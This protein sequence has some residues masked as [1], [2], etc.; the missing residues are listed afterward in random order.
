[1]ARRESKARPE[2][3][4]QQVRRESPARLGLRELLVR[5]VHRVPL[6]RLGQPGR[7]V[8]QAQPDQLVLLVRRS[9]WSEI[10]ARKEC[11]VLPAQPDRLELPVHRAL[12]LRDR[13]ARR[14]NRE[15]RVNRGC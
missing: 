2:S 8:P 10:R 14:E 5:L 6:V 13:P 4:V 7:L 11:S 1:V 3:R 15:I 12:D 9:G